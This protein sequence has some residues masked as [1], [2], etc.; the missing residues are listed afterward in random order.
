MDELSYND[1]R[2]IRIMFD[3]EWLDKIVYYLSTHKND[4]PF[5][6]KQLD[7][8]E[9]YFLRHNYDDTFNLISCYGAKPET[10]SENDRNSSGYVRYQLCYGNELKHRLIYRI[11]GNI[12]KGIDFDQME[13]H[14]KNG[15]KLDNRLNNLVLIRPE[16]HRILHRLID[17]YGIEN[18]EL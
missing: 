9:L 2:N 8:D 3:E 11:Y 16:S 1:Y 6:L 17:N 4:E 15:N 7:T 13:I 10:L 18:V 12:P 5:T 14:H